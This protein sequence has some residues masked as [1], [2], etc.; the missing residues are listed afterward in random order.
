MSTNVQFDPGGANLAHVE[1]NGEDWT[2]IVVKQFRHSPEKVWQAPTDPGE[3][4]QGAPFHADQSLATEGAKVKFTTVG[5]PQVHEAES[6][7]TKAHAPN[8]LEFNW[9]GGATRWQL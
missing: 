4:S 6:V 7:I 3:L 5:A 9:G 1:K 2:L 8:L